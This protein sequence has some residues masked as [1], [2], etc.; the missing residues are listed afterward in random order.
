M[1]SSA[2]LLSEDWAP[3]PGDFS[4]AYSTG[5]ATYKPKG[6]KR[7]IGAA[8][9]PDGTPTVTPSLE[10]IDDRIIRLAF[11]KRD[12]GAKSPP[13]DTYRTKTEEHG[14]VYSATDAYIAWFHACYPRAGG[15]DQCK[16]KV[17]GGTDPGVGGDEITF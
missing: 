10:N 15:R 16:R 11:G 13:L 8:L 2:E 12:L 9:P 4:D 14:V 3:E 6:C 17:S 5:N 1:T 7:Y